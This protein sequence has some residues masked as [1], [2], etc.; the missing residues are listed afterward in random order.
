M[1]ETRLRNAISQSL[2][3]ADFPDARKQQVLEQIR[4]EKP[5]KKKLSVALVCAIVLTMLFAGAALAAMLGIF[6]QLSQGAYDAKR[7]ENLEK[8]AD[9]LNITAPL[10]APETPVQT[11][12]PQT[13]YDE[14][15]AR[16]QERRFDLTLS[17]TYFDGKKLFYSYT[18]ATDEE[19]TWQGEGMPKGIP[20]WMIENPGRRYADVWSNDIPGRDEAITDWLNSHESSW[21]AHESWGLGDG[22]STADGTVLE[23]IGS[24]EETDGSTIRGYQE[25]VVPE[26][27]RDLDQ[28]EIEL[29]V[30]YGASLYHQDETGVRWAHI[31]QKEN[32]GILRIPFTVYRNGQTR[33]L[34]GASSFADYAVK[35]GL[36]VS[37]V[38]ISGTAILKVPKAWTDTL[39]DRIENRHDGDVIID[40]QLMAGGEVLPNHDCSLYTPMDGRLEISLQFDLPE[41]LDELMLAPV[42]AKA[43]VKTE[44]AI[45]LQEP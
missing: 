40:Y 19:Q 12:T 24:S 7:L 35:T 28:L 9:T 37:D 1:D 25:V 13:I 16:Q 32:R 31:A 22:A 45:T 10:A 8:A 17:Q 3:H 20:E 30:L 39:S 33:H 5:M 15:M 11:E 27:L 29:T 34:Q 14:I 4:G 44:E 26:E 6:G 36:S 41:K 2:A 18:L 38:E 42:Y 43:G 23:I 21:I